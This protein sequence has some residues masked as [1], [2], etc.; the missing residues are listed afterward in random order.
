[1]PSRRTPAPPPPSAPLTVDKMTRGIA[2]F[3]RLI[4]EIE[5]FD[6]SQLQKRNSPEVEALSQRIVDTVESVFGQGSP[7]ANDYRAAARLDS[8][9][10]R[11]VTHWNEHLQDEAGDA[12]RYVAEGKK[13]AVIHLRG[14]IKYLQDEIAD[15]APDEATLATVPAATAERSRD[16]FVVHGH[17][18]E[19]REAVARFIEKLDLNPIILNEQANRGGTVIEKFERHGGVA[20][21]AVVLLTPDDVGAKEGEDLQPRPRQNVVLELGFFI[22]RLGRP[23]VCALATSNDMELPSDM[24]GIVRE[25]FNPTNPSWK[26][27]LARELQAAGYVID[28]NKVMN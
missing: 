13:G 2:R 23:S 25:T 6:T 3:E 15:V 17:D 14:A 10:W 18:G 4:E 28:W 1:M 26:M 19:A 12:Q 5:A 27:A 9:P 22:G 20:G 8:G 11:T 16:V 7:K 21:F 24:G